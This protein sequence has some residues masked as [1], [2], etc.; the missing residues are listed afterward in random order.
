MS[1]LSTYTERDAFNE[2]L[3]NVV[4]EYLNEKDAHPAETMLAINLKTKTT[5]LGAKTEFTAG[6]EL[7]PIDKLI[8]IS[9][10]DE[11][12]EVDIDATFEIASSIYFVR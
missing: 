7:Y 5:K 12:E 1:D 4:E 10:D 3:Y 8:R 11:A 6:W 9:E 2:T